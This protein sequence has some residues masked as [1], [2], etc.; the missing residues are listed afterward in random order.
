MSDYALASA[1][2]DISSLAS[3]S[4][5]NAVSGT[6][7]TEIVAI[8]GAIVDVPTGVSGV[9]AGQ[10]IAI[11]ASGSDYVISC[12]VTG[13]T[14]DVTM[15]DLVSVSGT[16]QAE[17]QTVSSAIPSIANLATKTEVANV[18]ADVQIVSAAI[19]TLPTEEEIEFAEVDLS[20]YAL[21]SAIPD[22][23]N[24]VTGPT[25]SAIVDTAL[26]DV[27]S[28]VSGLVGGTNVSITA[29]GSNY[30]IDA[31]VP[32]VSNL[33]TKTEVTTGLGTKQNTLTGITDVQ[34]VQALPVSPVSTVLYLIPET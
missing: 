20:D 6:L 26:V 18:E 28:G 34:V 23:S 27:P 19:P 31:T 3:K 29:S 5:V 21:A 12:T 30:V 14:S 16:L 11:T 15:A 32:D 7:Q 4:E 13:G 2:P 25:V 17:I 10:G 9:V 24:F 1:I 22:V 33:A 8:S